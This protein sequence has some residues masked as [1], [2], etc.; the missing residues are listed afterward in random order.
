M[1]NTRVKKSI[2]CSIFNSVLECNPNVALSH[3]SGNNTANAYGLL[4]PLQHIEEQKQIS[5]PVIKNI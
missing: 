2:D 3:H 5:N 1:R 4:A